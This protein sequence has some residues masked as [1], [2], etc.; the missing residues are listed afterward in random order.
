M[1]HGY[2][3]GQKVTDDNYD[4]TLMQVIIV[5]DDNYDLH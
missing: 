1:F 3:R 4:L 5:T 2:K